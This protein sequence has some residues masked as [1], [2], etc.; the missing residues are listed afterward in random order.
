MEAKDIHKEM[1]PIWAA[2]PVKNY[3]IIGLRRQ[4]LS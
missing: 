1:L 4:I 3:G 2:F